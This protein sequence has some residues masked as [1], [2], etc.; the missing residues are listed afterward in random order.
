M[1]E[2]ACRIR[3][4]KPAVQAPH[5]PSGDVR[6][7]RRPDVIA[8]SSAAS[9]VGHARPRSSERIGV[10]GHAESAGYGPCSPVSADHPTDQSGVSRVHCDLDGDQYVTTLRGSSCN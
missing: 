10:R 9:V 7:R 6:R 3:G 4:S 5:H 2:A 1:A 8:D